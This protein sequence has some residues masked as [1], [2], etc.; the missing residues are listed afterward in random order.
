MYMRIYGRLGGFSTT[1]KRKKTDSFQLWKEEKEWK[2]GEY[3]LY[4]HVMSI[5][6]NIVNIPGELLD[7]GN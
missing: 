4:V 7:N 5:S 1:G 6:R 2:N 3:I